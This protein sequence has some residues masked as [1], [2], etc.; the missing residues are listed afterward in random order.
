MPSMHS[1]CQKKGLLGVVLARLHV[2]SGGSGRLP[3]P[4]NVPKKREYYPELAT[5]IVPR[6]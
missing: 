5:G 1:A 6:S 4:N 3:F 2:P